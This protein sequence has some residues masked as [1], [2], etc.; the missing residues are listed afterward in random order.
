[1]STARVTGIPGA[2]AV[3]TYSSG[4]AGRIATL[5]IG[6]V[7]VPLLA[8]GIPKLVLDVMLGISD[9]SILIA[10]CVALLVAGGVWLLVHVFVTGPIRFETDAHSV[11]LRKG[12][13]V[14][15]EWQRDSTLFAS[16]VERQSTYGVPSGSV[17]K[18]FATTS[19]ERTEVACRWFSASMFNDLMA[20]LSPVGGTAAST[21]QSVGRTDGA[22]S[23]T[24]DPRAGRAT[25]GRRAAW[26]I[27]LVLA[28]AG[29]LVGVAYLVVDS[30]DDPAFLV[31]LG[32]FAAVLLLVTAVGVGIRR[33]RAGRIPTTIVVTGSTLQV[34][35]AALYFAQLASI[36]LTPPGYSGSARRLVVVEKVGTRTRYPLGAAV[37]RGTAPFA[38]YDEFVQLLGRVAPAGLVRF[39]LR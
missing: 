29:F 3:R 7:A 11:R 1:M 23:F 12:P 10:V 22:R 31:G 9:S 21:Q 4:A 26:I 38:E 34:D 37:T 24:L 32:V 6:V 14:T 18:I 20:D 17:R 30:R 16:F 5:L 19:A 8:V 39:D 2:N 36:E 15:N 13:R 35:G 27:L 33:R 25:G 28:L